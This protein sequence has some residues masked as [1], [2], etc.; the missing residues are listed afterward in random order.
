MQPNC[1]SWK[2]SFNTFYFQKKNRIIYF[3]W[4]FGS[5]LRREWKRSLS[6]EFF[7]RDMLIQH[8][9][10]ISGFSQLTY[11]IVEK[12]QSYRKYLERCMMWKI[13]MHHYPAH[14]ILASK[15]LRWESSLE[16][17]IIHCFVQCIKVLK[18][19]RCMHTIIADIIW[20]GQI[21]F[22]I[23]MNIILYYNQCVWNE[24]F[25]DAA[26]LEWPSFVET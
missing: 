4:K 14:D 17:K 25:R 23:S 3:V 8:K 16:L 18:Q 5:S 7:P 19:R 10:L 13:R 21:N 2:L 6:M 26:A 1:F 20:M 9:K 24:G 11:W 12:S 15:N 22:Y